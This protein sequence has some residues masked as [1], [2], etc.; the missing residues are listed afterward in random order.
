M[1]CANVDGC[2]NNYANEC[3]EKKQK[4][5]CTCVYQRENRKDFLCSMLCINAGIVG[6]SG[7]FFNAFFQ[8]KYFFFLI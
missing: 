5:D 7:K 4:I 3:L 8:L 1:A 2:K 6:A